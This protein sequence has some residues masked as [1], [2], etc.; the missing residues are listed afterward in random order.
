MVTTRY[1]T[2]E[3]ISMARASY[4][5]SQEGEDEEGER[6]GG[7]HEKTGEDAV[8]PRLLGGDA[9][10]RDVQRRGATRGAA[11]LGKRAVYEPWNLGQGARPV[12]RLAAEVAHRSEERRVGK[13]WRSR[14]A[15]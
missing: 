8:A 9:L 5:F 7:G 2:T 12:R 1:R 4:S 10:A 14:W 11:S 3:P 13:E 15:P 6:E